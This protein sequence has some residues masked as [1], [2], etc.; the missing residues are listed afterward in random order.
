MGT[1]APRHQ[2]LVSWR[3]IN[4]FDP[5]LIDILKRQFLEGMKT[6]YKNAVL[7]EFEVEG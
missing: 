6:L 2:L 4:Y 1:A 7:S 3:A 5:A